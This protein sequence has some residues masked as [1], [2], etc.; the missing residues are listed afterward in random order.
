MLKTKL[1]D[2]EILKQVIDK[3]VKNGYEVPIY[4]NPKPYDII[5]SHEFCKAYFGEEKQFMDCCKEYDCETILWKYHI[6][7]L[8]L[9]EDRLGYLERYL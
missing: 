7:Q 1:T 3:A 4:N 6:K 2:E 8:A 9:S 5:F